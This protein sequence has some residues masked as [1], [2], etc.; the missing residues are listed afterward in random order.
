MHC[1][2]G[3][4][5]RCSAVLGREAIVS[6]CVRGLLINLLMCSGIGATETLLVV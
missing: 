2:V 4:P 6:I 3:L 1:G 5:M